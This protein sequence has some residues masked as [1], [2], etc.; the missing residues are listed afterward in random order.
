MKSRAKG[1]GIRMLNDKINPNMH[2]VEA[3]WLN[4]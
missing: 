4:I 2:I 1:E 3:D